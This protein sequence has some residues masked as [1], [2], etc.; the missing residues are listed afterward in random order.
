VENQGC[1]RVPSRKQKE[2]RGGGQ[3][4]VHVHALR[5]QY[6][7]GC[8]SGCLLGARCR[9]RRRVTSAAISEREC[10]AAWPRCTTTSCLPSC[11]QGSASSWKRT[12]SKVCFTT[13]NFAL[14]SPGGLLVASCLEKRFGQDGTGAVRQMLATCRSSMSN[15]VDCHFLGRSRGDLR[16]LCFDR[17]GVAAEHAKWS[18]VATA[19][20]RLQPEVSIKKVS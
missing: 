9:M 10:R 14:L 4:T 7:L 8:W 13:C 1:F 11:A 19:W 15:V 2:E 5:P 18:P 6:I 17:P 20:Y 3:L 12:A 16:F